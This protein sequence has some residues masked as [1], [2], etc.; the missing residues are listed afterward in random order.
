MAKYT[1]SQAKTTPAGQQWTE[2][3]SVTSNT[4]QNVK[5]VDRSPYQRLISHTGAK[6]V[7]Q[8]NSE[9]QRQE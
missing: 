7:L 8:R 3:G 2:R 4:C 9:Q 6:D 1:H 5:S